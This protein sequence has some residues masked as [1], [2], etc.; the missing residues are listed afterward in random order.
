[1]LLFLP[2]GFA[3]ACLTLPE[4]L[5]SVESITLKTFLNGKWTPPFEKKFTEDLSIYKPSRTFWGTA[6]Y[7]LF[8]DGRSGVVIGK[9]GWLFTSEEFQNTRKAAQVYADHMAYI[10]ETA[11]DLKAKGVKLVIAFIPAKAGVY[12]DELG[13][14]QYPASKAAIYK[15]TYATLA[16]KQIDVVNVADVFEGQ[17]D[18]FLKTD[19]HWTQRGAQLT[20]A[21]VAER[22][23]SVCPDCVTAPVAYKT[24]AAG[25]VIAHDGD[26]LRYI[27]VT[28]SVKT[29]LMQDRIGPLAT[30][31]AASGDADLFGDTTLPVVLVGTSYSANPLFNFAGYLKESLGSDLLNAA[32]QGKGPFVT[33]KAWRENAAAQALPKAVIWEI[34]ERYLTIADKTAGE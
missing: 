17:K 23:R 26:L 30:E 31:G 2:A 20:A 33:M 12:R 27:P 16:D 8:A 29:T 32:D 3:L 13:T 14:H 6:E 10:E 9:D 4:T 24:A 1:M 25:E 15:T 11:A 18:V 22:V 28:D 34:P 21:A 19:T 7:D 5:K